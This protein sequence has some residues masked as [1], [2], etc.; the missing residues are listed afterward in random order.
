MVAAEYLLLLKYNVLF[1]TSAILLISLCF[2]GLL[3]NLISTILTLTTTDVKNTLANS[4]TGQIA[5]MFFLF[6]YGYPKLSLIQ[7]IVHAFYKALL[8]MG[9]GGIIHQVK[10]NQDN[11]I[12]NVHYLSNPIL[13]T[14]LFIGLLNY[15]SIPG[16][17]SHYSKIN[18]LNL[19]ISINYGV[20]YGIWLIT[21]YSQIINFIAGISLL[22]ILLNSGYNNS[23]RVNKISWYNS[24]ESHNLLSLGAILLLSY[25]CIA[26]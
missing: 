20:Q 7:F 3:T 1:Q 12:I 10:N 15:I 8:F 4:T 6:G 26:F 23:I 17:F 24:W 9:F 18:L 11:R 13:Y 25:F 14:C 22:K 19:T 5:Y 2:V 21:E 16:F